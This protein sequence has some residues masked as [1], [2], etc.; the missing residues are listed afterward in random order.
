MNWTEHI[1]KILL[2]VQ[3]I[4]QSNPSLF[5]P[6]GKINTKGD[7]TIEMDEKIESD[8]IN[9]LKNNDLPVSVYSEEIGFIQIHKKP[10]YLLVFDPLDGSSN[11]K[12]GKGLLPFGFLISCYKGSHPALSDIVASGALEHTTNSSWIYDGKQ[13]F[14]KNGDK[15]SLS[16]SWDINRSTPVYFD[17]YY[18]DVY[19]SL[20]S[21]PEK[22][23]VRW[24]GSTI[25]SLLYTLS[26]ASSLMGTKR[27][28]PEE[29]GAVYSLLKGA[30][31]K[32]TDFSG[33]EVDKTP[34]NIQNHYQI[35]AGDSKVL[36]YVVKLL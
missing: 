5:K 10:S 8:V 11:Y 29:I 9:Y 18:K 36:D 32:I 15:I 14:D 23:H 20:L 26:G 3:N 13:T 25:S 35:I 31:A 4:I 2:L 34:F 7:R 16:T 24:N 1:H 30:G 19:N 21:L 22:V 33:I 6:T 17:L 28:T 27:M 12:F